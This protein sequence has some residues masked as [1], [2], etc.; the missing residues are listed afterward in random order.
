MAGTFFP[1]LSSFLIRYLDGRRGTDLER[2]TTLAVCS[3]AHFL[4]DFSCAFLL[5]H[6]FQGGLGWAELLVAYNLCAFAVQMPLGVLADRWNRDLVLAAVGCG[7][8]GAAYLG[9]PAWPAAVLAGLGNAAFHVGAG[10]EVFNAAGRRAGPLGVFVSPGAMGLYAGTLLG[11]S[12]LLPAPAPLM[13]MALAGAC[14]L[15]V[16]RMSHSGWTTE[17]PA[18]AL[19]AGKGIALPLLAL[20]AVVVLRSFVGMNLAFPW[21]GEDAWALVLTCALALG[22]AA[23]GFLADRFGAENTAAVSLALCAIFLLAGNSPLCGVAAVLLF[24]MTM[25]LTLWAAALLLPSARGFAFGLLTFG[26]FLGF[27]P[28]YFGPPGLGNLSAAAWSLASLAI[29]YPALRKAVSA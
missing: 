11:K 19:P 17:N 24:N 1:I 5:F 22:K 8:V 21:R 10:L 23:G 29:L 4:V 12:E 14:L 25:P 9:L 18:P 26:L 6:R 15:A 16:S 13:A 27:L 3:A 7:L 28:S 2:R 20:F